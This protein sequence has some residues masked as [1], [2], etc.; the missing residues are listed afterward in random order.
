MTDSAAR[1]EAMPR[2]YVI[3]DIHGCTELLD[4]IV[5]HI[6]RDLDRNPGA[7]AVTVTLGSSS[8]RKA[9]P[10]SSGS[11]SEE[12]SRAPVSSWPPLGMWV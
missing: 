8:M 5:D 3:G 7:E 12:R 11:A 1:T 10:W 6:R 9:S 4:R 2:L